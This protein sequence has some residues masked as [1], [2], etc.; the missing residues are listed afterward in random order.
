MTDDQEEWVFD[1]NVFEDADYMAGAYLPDQSKKGDVT[2]GEKYLYAAK[3]IVDNTGRFVPFFPVCLL[4][5]HGMELTL[6]GLL[7]AIWDFQ[8]DPPSEQK[9]SDKLHEHSLMKLYDRLQ[10]YAV[11]QVGMDSDIFDEE[12]RELVKAIDEVDQSGARFRYSEL[13]SKQ[14]GADLKDVANR[15]VDLS[16]LV[17][18]A[19]T[20]HNRLTASIGVSLERARDARLEMPDPR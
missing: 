17:D 5:R 8:V 14:E 1:G 3:T 9:Q 19:Q 11:E 20:F 12:S 4:V 15:S 10:C 16:V 13:R 6:K 2:I 7:K 18:R